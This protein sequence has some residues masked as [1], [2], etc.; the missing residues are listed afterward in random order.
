MLR[1]RVKADAGNTC[2]VW[3][4]CWCVTFYNLSFDSVS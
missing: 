3:E 2:I 1:I 4:T